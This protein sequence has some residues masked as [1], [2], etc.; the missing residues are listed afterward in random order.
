MD[1]PLTTRTYADFHSF[2]SPRGMRAAFPVHA[3][4]QVQMLVA[5]GAD[6][7]KRDTKGLTA[8]H[9]GCLKG[10]LEVVKF[11]CS[12]CQRYAEA[13]LTEKSKSKFRI[14][15]QRPQSPIEMAAA[16]GHLHTVLYLLQT[17]ALRGHGPGPIAAQCCERARD[18]GHTAVAH[19]LHECGDWTALHF[20]TAAGEREAARTLL[21]AGADPCARDVRGVT[22]RDVAVRHDRGAVLD[23]LTAATVWRPEAHGLFP[24]PFRN[25]IRGLVL[26]CRRMEG[27]CAGVPEDVWWAVLAYLPRSFGAAPPRT[28]KGGAFLLRASGLS[29]RL[30][31]RL[32][33]GL[34]L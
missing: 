18:N 28:R 5:A 21:A 12:T 31:E 33:S 23:V 20:C 27:V 19:A 7:H 32:T 22:P 4:H 13:L 30:G 2:P 10:H 1:I 25:A 34:S 17:L 14:P 29:R 24:R 9:T 8:L 15:R 3:G 11:L 6:L 16:N 26:T